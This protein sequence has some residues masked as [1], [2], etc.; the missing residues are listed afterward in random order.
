M[1][2]IIAF[3]AVIAAI[4]AG[5][6]GLRN[7]PTP[8]SRGSAIRN[9]FHYLVL[10]VALLVTVSGAFGVLGRLLDRANRVAG[11]S[12]EL[13]LG[14]AAL[15][16]GAPIL[17]LFARSTVR[18]LAS[19]PD[20]TETAGWT[21]FTTVGS[22]VTLIAAMVGAYGLVRWIAGVGT[23]DGFALA[24]ALT[25]GTAWAALWRVDARY[26]APP[27]D[28]FRHLVGSLIGLG[29][30]V[31]A[32][33]GIVAAVV[34]A[35]MFRSANAFV[36]RDADELRTS[37]ALLAV[38]AP[39]WVVY[40]ATTL[41]RVRHSIVWRLQTVLVGVAGG[42]LT[43]LVSAATLAYL[44][45]VWWFGTPTSELARR[46][47]EGAPAVTGAV[48]AGLLVWWYHRGLVAE[49]TGGGRSELDRVYVHVMSAGGLLASAVGT[50]MLLVAAVDALTGTRIVRGDTGVNALILAA[51]SLAVGAPVWWGYWNAEQRRHLSGDQSGQ[52]RRVYLV[53][54]LGIAGLAAIGAA[55]ATLYALLDD[56][57][58]GDLASATLRSM[59][60]PLAIL[61][62]AGVVAVYHLPLARERHDAPPATR[63]LGHVLLIG[64]HDPVLV[65]GVR[66]LGAR[67]VETWVTSDASPWPRAAVLDHLRTLD[68]GDA[69]VFMS[70]GVARVESAR[71]ILH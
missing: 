4:V 22:I 62:T 2:S 57:L 14:L 20:E 41:G 34:E 16:V 49:E 59:R 3:V 5:S 19:E 15:V 60:Y 8:T 28:A 42:V 68:G 25:W 50:T 70:N 35:I 38:G 21:L 1:I 47:F 45:L 27:R 46:H 64:M 71:R 9:F 12:S 23:F 67:R 52:V 58:D 48:V 33:G 10:L 6:R 66:T 51:V 30:S 53:T 56:L 31:T 11:D 61:V 7:R 29:V 54:V 40:W 36:A 32:I 44:T 43:T 17:Y 13:A 37:L 69:I 26:T 63:R 55:I 65:D 24:Q 39:V 18:R